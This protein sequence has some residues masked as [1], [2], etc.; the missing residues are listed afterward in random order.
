MDALAVAVAVDRVQGFV[1]SGQGF[2]DPETEIHVGDNRSTAL[3]VLRVMNQSLDGNALIA[4]C[5]AE[6]KFIPT[7]EDRAKAQEIFL[8]FDEILVMDKLSD[9]L[10]KQ[11]TDGRINDF[12]LHMSQMF[13]KDEIDVTKE[14]AML[15][16]LPNSRRVSEKRIEMEEFYNKNRENGYVGNIK[17]RL[18]LAGRV[19]DVKFIPRHGVHLTTVHTTDGKLV[20]FFMNENL[21][22]LAENINGQNITFMGTVKKQEVNSYTGCQETMVNRVKI[23]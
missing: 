8:H 9:D 19:I 4:E 15:V 2:Y 13:A 23:D 7:D 17:S 5:S 10:V 21:R 11:G 12:N 22:D 14:L 20:K 3:A 16:S 6:T 1:K 18:K